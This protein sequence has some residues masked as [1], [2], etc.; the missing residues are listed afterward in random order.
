MSLLNGKRI[1]GV[2]VRHDKNTKNAVTT[3]IPLPQRVTIPMQQHM[4][5][6]CKPL[7]EVGDRVLVGQ[8]IGD[9]EHLF[10]AP[11]HSSVSG[12]VEALTEITLPGGKRSQAVVIRADGKQEEF[13]HRM[14]TITTA[15][16]FFTAVRRSGLVGLGGAGFPAH[17]KLAYKDVERLDTLVVNAAECEPYI[18]SD[19]R[20]CIESAG[21]VF[22]GIEVVMHFLGLTHCFIGIEKNKPEAI[23]KLGKICKADPRIR[24]VPL[25]ARYP[26]G[27]EKVLIYQ[28][29]GRK[30]RAGSLPAD[31]GVMMQNV[32][33]IAFLADYLRHGRPL[34][35]RFITV[36]GTAVERPGNYSVPVGTSIREVLEYCGGFEKATQILSGGPMMGSA[37]ADPDMPVTKTCNALLAFTEPEDFSLSTTDCIRCGRCTAACPMGLRPGMLEDAYDKRDTAQ[38]RALSVNLCVGCGSCSYVCPAGRPLSQK[39][40]LAKDL[41]RKE[42]N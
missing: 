40:V 36:D 27:A 16:D 10:A 41:L 23:E 24:V 1:N 19:Y 9:T 22:D 39:N 34:I 14:P 11:V 25:P 4:G 3:P 18:T 33:S 42:G 15:Q 35:E 20:T 37:V 32:S 2:T 30:V 31:S 12:E 21:D 5:V 38:L 26:Q 17:M 13:P 29:T 7:V 8:K 6:P 28:T